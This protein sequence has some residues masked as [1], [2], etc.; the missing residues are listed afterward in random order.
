MP[1]NRAT[2]VPTALARGLTRQCPRCGQGRLF[3]GWYA[4]R[5]RCSNCD[6]DLVSMYEHTWAF[7]YL[8]TAFLT[9]SIVVAMF[10][11]RPSAEGWGRFLYFVIAVILIVGSLPNRKGF[12]LAIEYLV[13]RKWG[14]D[15]PGRLEKASG[16]PGHNVVQRD[17]VA[18][19][20]A[21][22]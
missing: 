13:E 19:R 3:D 20:N 9:G 4:V 6:L 21:E 22:R 1:V 10:L 8:S 12:A 16:D 15:E 17:E 2:G 5:T 18:P 11:L 14:N 7:M